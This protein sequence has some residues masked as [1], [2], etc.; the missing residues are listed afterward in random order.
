MNALPRITD[1]EQQ[2]NDK[3]DEICE[4]LARQL[5]AW[6]TLSDELKTAIANDAANLLSDW[7]AQVKP[8]DK[9]GSAAANAVTADLDLQALLAGYWVT[10]GELLDTIGADHVGSE[11][12]LPRTEG[13]R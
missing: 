4:H 13:I 1:L 12:G 2:K 10:M 3:F 7:D 5:G 11:F 9:P 8:T 6:E